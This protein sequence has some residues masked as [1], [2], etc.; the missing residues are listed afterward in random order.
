MNITEYCHLAL[1]VGSTTTWTKHGHNR[2]PNAMHD[3]RNLSHGLETSKF[4]R[5]AP[6]F[7]PVEASL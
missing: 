5:K 3:Y 4:P 7:T 1:Y 6:N 2:T